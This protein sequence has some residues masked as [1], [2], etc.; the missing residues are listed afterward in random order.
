MSST[1]VT[2]ITSTELFYRLQ[3]QNGSCKVTQMP[4]F[5]S[6]TFLQYLAKRFLEHVHA[7]KPTITEQLLDATL[8]ITS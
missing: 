3:I 4:H 1:V 2:W 8:A 5:V 6:P 7:A